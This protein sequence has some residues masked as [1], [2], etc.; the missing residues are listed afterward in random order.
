VRELEWI[1][2]SDWL[3]EIALSEAYDQEHVSQLLSH[4]HV[5]LILNGVESEC[6]VRVNGEDV[7]RTDSSFGRFVLNV[8]ERVKFPRSRGTGFDLHNSKK[9]HST[10]TLSLA[11]LFHSLIKEARKRSSQYPYHV[12]ASE[13]IDGDPFVNYL[14]IGQHSFG[15]D[16][17]PSFASV[18][19][20]EEADGVRLVGFDSFF[21]DSVS[22]STRWESES[23]YF[24]KVVA[25]VI[26][27]HEH[28]PE[29]LRLTVHIPVLGQHVSFSVNDLKATGAAAHVS[30]DSPHASHIEIHKEFI[31]SNPKLW[32]PT[33]Y[34][35]PTLYDV[36]TSLTSSTDKQVLTKKV[37]F[38]KVE[39]IRTSPPG[40]YGSPF[41]FKVNDIRIFMKGAN[42]IPLSPFTGEA[43]DEHMEILLASAQKSNMN[44]IRVWGGGIY[45]SEEFYKRA[46]ELGLMVWQEFVFACAMYPTDSSFLKAVRTE[47][48]SQVQRLNHHPSIIVWGGSNENEGALYGETWYSQTITAENKPLF[49]V[50]FQK[51]YLNVIPE[52]LNGEKQDMSRPYIHSSPSNG[53]LSRD[54]PTLK[55]TNP[56]KGNEGDTHYYN[57][58]DNCLDVTKFPLSRFVSEYGH[59]SFPSFETLRADTIFEDWSIDSP[60][61]RSRQH[62]PNGTAELLAQMAMHFRNPS[63]KDATKEFKRQIYLTQVMQSMCV[64]QQS[65]WYRA[66][67]GEG[68]VYTMG[69]L[70]WQLND[71]WSAP[72]WASIDSQYRWKLL[73]YSV[74]EFFS[75]Q[76]VVAFQPGRW[77]K[78][79]HVSVD[80]T[81]IV[82][83]LN[84]DMS[85]LK[86]SLVLKM[87]SWSS[88]AALDS[89]TLNFEM[90]PLHS[91]IVHEFHPSE[92]N[93]TYQNPQ[94]CVLL[95]QL[96]NPE[97]GAIIHENTLPLSELK[98]APLIQPNIHVVRMEQIDASH[99]RVV[100]QSDAMAPHVSVEIVNDGSK[101]GPVRESS[102]NTISHAPCLGVFSR[103]NFLMRPSIE[104]ALDYTCWQASSR[105]TTEELENSLR[106][107]SLRDSYD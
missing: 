100:L 71:L 25:K 31:V 70:Y 87:L 53:M 50:D 67:R 88:G 19:V 11:F 81:V 59:Q 95:L 92:L 49:V 82:T 52:V 33:G 38:R 43:T 37:G 51:L 34:G 63:T 105:V 12:P 32:Y 28:M 36:Q 14:R 102:Q 27:D 23:S 76:A 101:G 72:T 2:Q 29:D 57:Y 69:A 48:R 98:D 91:R 73:H 46:D 68:A 26:V 97:D 77:E 15:W 42:M 17:G 20:R 79:G 64:K 85:T 80:N 90:E 83:V 1:K 65:E 24:L 30:N 107:V 89:K 7:F 93:C 54:P 45:Q 86:A 8:T 44:M 106:I 4:R 60:L 9:S 3:Y 40:S 62:H 104:Y 74:K 103:N 39:L 13:Y 78:A 35:E 5:L 66:L 58:V 61:F 47:V 41:F 16:W 96:T 99:V 6:D 55:W 56:W 84:D 22:V 18:G 10:H 21:L 94:D 75:P